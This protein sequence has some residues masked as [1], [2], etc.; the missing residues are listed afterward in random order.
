[1]Q[2]KIILLI[3]GV[4]LAITMVMFEISLKK[5]KKKIVFKLKPNMKDTI[6]SLVL[7]YFVMLI[8]PIINSSRTI[9]FANMTDDTA[10]REKAY[11]TVLVI[12]IIYF[13]Y[14]IYLLSI[15]YRTQ[16]RFYTDYFV[17]KRKLKYS[18]IMYYAIDV[19]YDYIEVYY[20]I[21]FSWIGHLLIKVNEE[22]KSRIIEIFNE[23]HVEFKSS[24][25]LTNK[26]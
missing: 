22:E 1:M 11:T 12:V 8:I 26:N 24:G 9:W 25:T 20:P 23:H 13:F 14:C 17:F 16:G 18:K 15:S 6:T 10:L 3:L 5:S 4:L 2:N 19:K 21:V 7:A